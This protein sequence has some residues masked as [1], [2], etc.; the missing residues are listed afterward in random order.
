MAVNDR[1]SPTAPT[2]DVLLVQ[3]AMG[4]L[5]LY[6]GPVD[7]IA[8]SDTLIAVRAYKRRHGLVVDKSLD[9]GFV[10]HVRRTV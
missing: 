6:R 1:G 3:E 2:E 10:E 7:G 8:N 4:R 5:G 9:P